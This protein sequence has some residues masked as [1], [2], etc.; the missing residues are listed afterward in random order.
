MRVGLLPVRKTK[1]EEAGQAEEKEA[2]PEFV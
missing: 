2:L 1:P